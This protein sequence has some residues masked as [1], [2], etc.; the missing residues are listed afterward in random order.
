MLDTANLVAFLATARPEESKRFYHDK[1]GLL[2][3]Q[4]DENHIVFDSNGTILRIQRVP[5]HTPSGNVALSWEVDNILSTVATLKAAG[6][7]FEQMPGIEQDENGIWMAYDGTM[8]AWFKDPDGNLL[9]LSEHA[10]RV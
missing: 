3:V 4:D 5:N 9:S 1:L 8:V 10:E 6:I 2:F 7:Q